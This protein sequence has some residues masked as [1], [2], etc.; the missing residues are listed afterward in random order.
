MNIY[1]PRRHLFPAYQQLFGAVS[2]VQPIE[3]YPPVDV[4]RQHWK[5]VCDK[6][7]QLCKA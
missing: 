5:A 2:T 1:E 6:S 4:L 7:E 3:N